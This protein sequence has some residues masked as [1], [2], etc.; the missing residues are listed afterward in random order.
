M[1]CVMLNEMYRDDIG[2][3]TLGHGLSVHAHQAVP[4]E[5]TFLHQQTV[6]TV[7]SAPSDTYREGKTIATMAFVKEK[8][9]EITT[10]DKYK[11]NH[12]KIECPF[13]NYI[14]GFRPLK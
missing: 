4:D 12:V 13:L 8:P 11:H 3:Q 6:V 5:F 10:P 2:R 1:K 14:P 9:L 7:C